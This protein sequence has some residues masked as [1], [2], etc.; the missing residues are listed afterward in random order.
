MPINNISLG[1][2]NSPFIG[3]REAKLIQQLPPVYFGDS[4]GDLCQDI[5]FRGRIEALR[6]TR[7]R[8]YGLVGG[9]SILGLPSNFI[10]LPGDGYDLTPYFV[11]S[12]EQAPLF[13]IK[14]RSSSTIAS[15][16]GVEREEDYKGKGPINDTSY[17]KTNTALLEF[18]RSYEKVERRRIAHDFVRIIASPNCP[19]IGKKR[20]EVVA[21]FKALSLKPKS[22][23]AHASQ[24]APPLAQ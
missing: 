5:F 9:L 3:L 13:L 1:L 24:P 2:E 11:Q 18:S 21:L 17:F 22:Y 7:K 16:Q 14:D 10:N 4:L 6:S 12:G 15:W 20:E 8:I 23:D 19:E